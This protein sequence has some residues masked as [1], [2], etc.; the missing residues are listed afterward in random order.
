M[1]VIDVVQGSQAWHQWRRSGI[2]ASES[3][4]LLDDNTEMTPWQL[5]FSKVNDTHETQMLA[6]A[7]IHPRC[8]PC[9]A[10]GQRTEVTA[11]RAI[12]THYQWL[13]LPLCAQCDIQPWLRASFDGLNDDGEPVEIKCPTDTV[14][15][16]VQQHREH[17]EAYQRYWPQVQHQ[18]CVSQQ[19]RGWLIFYCQGEICAVEIHADTAYHTQ[20]RDAGERFWQQVRTHTAPDLDPRRDNWQPNPEDA[21]QWQ[22]LAQRYQQL[23]REQQPLK[24]QVAQQQQRLQ[25][26]QAQMVALMGDFGYAQY[27]GVRLCR[28]HRQGTV[29][30]SALLAD[31]HGDIS[32]D[33]LNRYRRAGSEQ[34]RVTLEEDVVCTS[35]APEPP[36]AALAPTTPSSF[37]F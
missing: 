11:R 8:N 2:G 12:E 27:E 9:M 36:N 30:Y 33:V 16:Q 26:V 3:A 13:L 17:S 1:K 20:L 24:A 18:L 34:V 32:N 6:Q 19:S 4:V 29:D 35:T 23:H 21:A 31:H 14:F 37:Y 25:Q 10:H 5:W 15:D 22:R 7:G 28:F